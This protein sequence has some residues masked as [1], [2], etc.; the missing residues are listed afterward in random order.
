MGVCCNRKPE[1]NPYSPHHLIKMSACR[2]AGLCWIHQKHFA[3]LIIS[4]SYAD[5]E[6]ATTDR[7]GKSSRTNQIVI[8][9]ATGYGSL[10]LCVCR[11]RKNEKQ[12]REQK[13]FVSMICTHMVVQ[14]KYRTL[15]AISDFFTHTHT[16]T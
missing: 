11:D 5:W 14:L 9:H 13:E 7:G 8:K 1:K 3:L 12:T 2:S 16:H 6:R 4:K 10:T 15:R